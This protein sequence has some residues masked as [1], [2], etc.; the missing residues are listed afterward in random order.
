MGLSV[1]LVFIYC[2]STHV[3]CAIFGSSLLASTIIGVEVVMIQLPYQVLYN[4]S[5]MNV[6]PEEDRLDISKPL[7]KKTEGVCI[8]KLPISEEVDRL[9]RGDIRD[10]KNCTS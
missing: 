6:Q 10:D 5:T 9:D 2:H 8:Q 1:V 4:A 7:Y 3:A